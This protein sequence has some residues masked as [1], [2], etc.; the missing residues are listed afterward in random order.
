MRFWLCFLTTACLLFPRS[1]ALAQDR[2]MSHQVRS[3]NIATSL[4]LKRSINKVKGLLV[5]GLGNGDFAGAAS[6]MIITANKVGGN[7]TMG[8]RFSQPVGESMR[9]S[10]TE[11]IRGLQVK[12][13]GWPKG[14]EASISFQE[15]YIPK[16]GPS[17]AVACALL[18]DGLIRDIEYDQ[19]FAVTG[20]M[21]SDLSVQPIGGVAAKIRGATKAKCKIVAVPY[22]NAKA[23]ADIFVSKDLRAFADIQVFTVKT[24]DDASKLA[25]KKRDPDLEFAITEFAKVQQVIAKNG[26]QITRNPAVQKKL[27]EILKRAPNHQS[28]RLLMYAGQGRGPKVYSLATSFKEMNQVAEPFLKAIARGDLGKKLADE[29]YGDAL[30]KMRQMRPQL[31][32]RTRPYHDAMTDMVAFWREWGEKEIAS[33]SKAMEAQRKFK[34]AVHRLE[35]EGAAL[36]NNKEIADEMMMMRE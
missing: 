36:R 26:V 20:D 15:K 35:K 3:P 5:S 14:F 10:V 1:A 7:G 27:T 17:A 32:E 13:G 16:D 4:E 34:E 33:R 12:Y 25:V 11:S 19:D 21:N 8:L 24:F 23:L 28:A 18:L 2:P 29:T 22:G 6:T 31:D 30:F 9:R